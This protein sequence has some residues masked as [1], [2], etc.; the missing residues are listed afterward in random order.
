M[1]SS[2]RPSSSGHRRCLSDSCGAGAVT[3]A[4]MATS[5]TGQHPWVAKAVEREVSEVGPLLGTSSHRRCGSMGSDARIPV[6]PTMHLRSTSVI[7]SPVLA[8]HRRCRSEGYQY[9][10][11]TG[12]QAPLKCEGI[13]A[14]E[15]KPKVLQLPPEAEGWTRFEVDLWQLS[16]GEYHPGKMTQQR[17]IPWGHGGAKGAPLVGTGAYQEVP[18]RVSVVSPTMSSRQH[19]HEQLWACFEAQ[20]WED[21]ELI[22]VET[23]ETSPSVFLQEM[24]KKDSRLIHISFRR[25][26]GRDFSVGLKRNMTMHLASGSYIA[27]FDDDDIYA[28]NY[29]SKM[30]GEIQ[31]K[32]VSAITLSSWYNYIVPRKVCAYSD[33]VLAHL[34]TDETDADEL[35]E[36]LYGYGFSYVH[37]RA[38]GL[39]L[40]YPD[41]VFAEDA[42]FYL[43]MRKELGDS[44][45]VLMRDEEGLCMHI[46]H[47]ANSTG[48]EGESIS[49]DLKPA[50]VSKLA[51]AD[52]PV[53]Q[54]FL[55]LNASWWE[56]L[57][58]P[59]WQPGFLSS[60]P[61]KGAAVLAGKG[62][63]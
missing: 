16:E 59:R 17:R 38:V 50:E 41:V 6:G 40:P 44:K 31:A 54:R 19:Y 33:P 20:T 62:A 28:A 12:P 4:P 1:A 14:P 36:I 10:A 8:G 26:V 32:G 11:F 22:V 24:A 56:M 52:L 30:V 45:V 34:D 42:P 63:C 27:N 5:S 7:A 25:P 9:L 57:P 49:H 58:F 13:D 39:A 46:V 47:R 21:K 48:V 55:E 18:G 60:P 53:F 15:G 23:Y 29:L 35:D 37:V 51:V 3:V 43:K 61:K 2:R